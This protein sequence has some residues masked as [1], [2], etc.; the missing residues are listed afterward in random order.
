MTTQLQQL[1]LYDRCCVDQRQWYL[2]LAAIHHWQQEAVATQKWMLAAEQGLQTRWDCYWAH[3]VAA[4]WPT[5][6]R[7]WHWVQRVV[8][9]QD[10]TQHEYGRPW[11]QQKGRWPQGELLIHSAPLPPAATR[12]GFWEAG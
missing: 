1:V 6:E 7:Q 5:V 3:L 11:H 9:V 10:H 2:R 8:H 12:R 4:V